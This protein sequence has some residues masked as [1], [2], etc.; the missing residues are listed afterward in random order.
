AGRYLADSFVRIPPANDSAFLET[1]LDICRRQTIDLLIPIVDYEFEPLSKNTKR[2]LAEGTRVVISS[3][4][5]IATC[6]D[7]QATVEW[8]KSHGLPVAAIYSREDVRSNHAPFPLFV[9]P[10][11]GGRAS[12]GAQRVDNERELEVACNKL[13]DPLIMEFIDGEEFT[14][15]TLSDF[16]GRFI[17]AMPR[18][19]IE[20][21]AGISVKGVTV[22][23]PEMTEIV[24]KITE[25]LPIIGPANIQCFRRRDGSIVVS[26]VNPRF[27]AATVLSIAAGFN[28]P[29]LLIKLAS[30][31]SV[32]ASMLTMRYGVTML[33]YVQEVFVFDDGSIVTDPWTNVADRKGQ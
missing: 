8:L 1:V 27:A 21:K 13:A 22:R 5:A 28:S 11:T 14:V 6:A 18:L 20:T 9:K 16:A 24:K 3:P 29:L 30:G 10:R 25:A 19:R 23:S 15:D 33:R 7:K 2:F 31:Q 17:A 32:E 4:Q 26:E 12:L